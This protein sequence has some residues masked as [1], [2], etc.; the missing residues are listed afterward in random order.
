MG[1][2]AD[3]RDLASMPPSPKV[4]VALAP[5]T[6]V[7]G[8]AAASGLVQQT[9]IVSVAAAAPVLAPS[10]ATAPAAAAQADTHMTPAAAAAAAA[11]VT[12]GG[13][14]AFFVRLRALDAAGRDVLPATWSDN[15]ITL[16]AG[17]TTQVLLEY[18]SG[19]AEVTAVTAEPFNK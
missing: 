10:A 5:P 1:R 4:Q 13:G 17:Q 11:G 12:T 15:F 2:Y 18:E 7:G 16:L 8:K 3:M 9:V 19:G 14:I 6:V